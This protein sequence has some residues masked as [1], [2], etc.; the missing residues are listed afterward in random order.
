MSQRGLS[1]VSAAVYSRAW[2]RAPRLPFPR[3]TSASA[4]QSGSTSRAVGSSA[5]SD[6]SAHFCLTPFR[7]LAA[8]SLGGNGST[9]MFQAGP[10]PSIMMHPDRSTL[11]VFRLCHTMGWMRPSNTRFNSGSAMPKTAQS[12]NARLGTNPGPLISVRLPTETIRAIDRWAKR[13][14][15][16]RPE[17]IRRL[18]TGAL[19]ASRAAA[20][21]KVTRDRRPHTKVLAQTKARGETSS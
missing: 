17:A 11:R 5:R 19:R 18:L 10:G 8:L 9:A 7:G 3:V 2:S 4:G 20:K 16:T 15:I 13:S 6:L 12:K 21:L 14:D 1:A